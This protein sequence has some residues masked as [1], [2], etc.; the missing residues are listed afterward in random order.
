MLFIT[1]GGAHPPETLTT[2]LFWVGVPVYGIFAVFAL[3]LPELYPTRLRGTGAGF[4]Y[5]TGRYLAS[6]G[7]LI[8]GALSAGGTIPGFIPTR[9]VD[10]LGL[11][12]A[13]QCFPQGGEQGFPNDQAALLERRKAALWDYWAARATTPLRR[14]DTSEGIAPYLF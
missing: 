5:N 2:L 8:T 11:M 3:W 7:P 4:C 10:L 1:F 13:E 14:M 6:A 9:F 12:I